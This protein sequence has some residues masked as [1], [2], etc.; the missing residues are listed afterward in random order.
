MFSHVVVNDTTTPTSKRTPRTAHATAPAPAHH[1]DRA[2]ISIF[3]NVSWSAVM[4]ARNGRCDSPLHAFHGAWSPETGQRFFHCVRP[5]A[6]RP[7]QTS[8]A[9]PS[10]PGGP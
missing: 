3:A 1:S 10:L 5:P 7:R 8:P 6:S 9:Q 2:W 4:G